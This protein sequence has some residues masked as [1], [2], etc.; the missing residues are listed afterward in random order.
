MAIDGIPFFSNNELAERFINDI[1]L[2]YY[3]L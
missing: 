3:K 2:L 1:I